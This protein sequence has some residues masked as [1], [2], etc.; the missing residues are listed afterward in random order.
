[1]SSKEFYL[2]LK[3]SFN[4]IFPITVVI[5]AIIFLFAPTTM[6]NIIKLLIS[7]VFLIFG[8]ALFTLGAD[9]A[10][11]EFGDGVGSTLSK[12]KNLFIVLLTSLVIGFIITFAEPD[13]TILA[14][15]VAEF[16]NMSSIYIFISAVSLGVGFS[17]VLGILRIFFNIKL[18]ILLL[19]SYLIVFILAFFVP[20]E[21]VPVIYDAGGVTTG[22]ISVPFLI[23]FGLGLSANRKSKN[24][25]DTNFGLIALSSV[26]PIISVMI[27]SLFLKTTNTSTVE[28]T[29]AVIGIAQ[30]IFSSLGHCFYQVAIIILP[31]IVLFIIF[32]ISFFKY[33]KTK[34]TRMFLGFLFTYL[35]IVLFLTGVECGYLK[36]GQLIGENLSALNNNWLAIIIGFIIGAFAIIAEPSLHILKKQVEDITNGALKKS[37]IMIC[38]SLGV[39]LAVT[40]AVIRALYPFNIL[41]I[42]V[43]FYTI[44]LVLAFFNTTIFTSVAF[45]S[46]GIATGTM[47]V[48]FILPF[49][50]GLSSPENS[51]FGTIAL[52]ACF[53]IF[54][55]Q[56]LGFIYKLKLIKINRFYTKIQ[57]KNDYIIDFDYTKKYKENKNLN[58]A[59]IDFD[60]TKSKGAYK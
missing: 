48:S 3:D 27:L 50:T 43:P 38:V 5:F 2:K 30:E 41:Y 25:E 32:Q 45:D 11:I 60:Y 23:A 53:P 17:L 52:I 34:V 16:S 4:S 51:G 44:S 55:M 47:A 20:Q 8:T 9:S 54:T 58:N 31:I 1:M 14:T 35:G 57:F 39:A 15:Q 46:G 40:V 26:G 36:I 29:N 6:D 49:I 22:S 59:V 18:S 56:L 24:G 12:C 42:F 21:F 13:I 19:I 28:E 37:I 33:P 10:M 7:A